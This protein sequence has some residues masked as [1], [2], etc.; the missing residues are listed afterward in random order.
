MH[1]IRFLILIYLKSANNKQLIK[2]TKKSNPKDSKHPKSQYF[3]EY[4]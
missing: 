4:L 3:C 1:L 2:A